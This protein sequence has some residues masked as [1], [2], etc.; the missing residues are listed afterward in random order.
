[1]APDTHDHLLNVPAF[2]IWKA[3]LTQP[4]LNRIELNA[5]KYV[6]GTNVGPLDAFVLINLYRV[7]V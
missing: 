6:E 3:G 1:M 7:D 5:M 2:A 4:Y